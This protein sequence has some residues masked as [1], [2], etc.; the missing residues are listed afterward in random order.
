MNGASARA[1]FAWISSAQSSLPVPASPSSKSGAFV[2]P[3]ATRSS[4]GYS[5]LIAR[6]APIIRPKDSARASFAMAPSSARVTESTVAPIR[7]AS[8]PQRIASLIVTPF[9]VVPFVEP[10]SISASASALARR[11]A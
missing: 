5:F 6:L 3:D 2:A 4:T 1:L 10:R 7:T 8:P 11:D 9:T